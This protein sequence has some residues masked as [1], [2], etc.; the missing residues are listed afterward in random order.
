MI[1]EN[2]RV[3]RA[4]IFNGIYRIIIWRRMEKPN[5]YRKPLICPPF[6]NNSYFVLYGFLYGHILRRTQFPQFPDFYRDI[7]PSIGDKSAS[8]AEL[9]CVHVYTWTPVIRAYAYNLQPFMIVQV[10]SQSSRFILKC[11]GFCIV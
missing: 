1:T 10:C 5:K 11:W 2:P 3:R 9:I 4:F 8:W 6:V 7:I